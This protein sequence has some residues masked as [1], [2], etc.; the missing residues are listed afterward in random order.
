[1]NADA[2]LICI[3]GFVVKTGERNSYIRKGIVFRITG[4][5]R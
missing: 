2:N 1:M 3:E 4:K 5:E